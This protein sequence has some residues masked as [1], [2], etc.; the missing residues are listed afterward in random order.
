MRKLLLSAAAISSFILLTSAGCQH[1]NTNVTPDQQTGTP[2]GKWTIS[3]YMDSGKNETSDYTGYSFEFSSGG[4]ITAE[5]SGQVT[6]GTWNENTDD[7]KQKFRIVLNTSDNKL[8]KLNHNW[9]L[10]TK[11]ETLIALKDDN[12]EGE[13]LHFS[14]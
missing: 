4:T 2:S 5:R 10:T 13:E 11:N 1:D 3:L 12:S 6:S 8:S 7:S 14:K 9:L